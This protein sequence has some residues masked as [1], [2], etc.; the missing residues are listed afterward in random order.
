MTA[1]LN[2]LIKMGEVVANEKLGK[3]KTANS[4]SKILQQSSKNSNEVEIIKCFSIV[5]IQTSA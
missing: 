3:I 5:Q 1:F 4:I 2:N